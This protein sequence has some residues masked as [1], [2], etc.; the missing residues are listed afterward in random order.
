MPTEEELIGWRDRWERLE[1]P[2][3]NA[4]SRRASLLQ[5]S[6]E[7]RAFPVYYRWRAL[8]EEAEGRGRKLDLGTFGKNVRRS[9]GRRKR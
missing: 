4:I 9:K 7:E 3:R 2:L 1:A 6:E 8:I 5:W